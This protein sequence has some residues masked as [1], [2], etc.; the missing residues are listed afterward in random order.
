MQTWETD[1]TGNQR[2]KGECLDMTGSEES[3]KGEL[4]EM[5]TSA[6]GRDP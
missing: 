1:S 3:K 2:D 4:D 5:I 6:C